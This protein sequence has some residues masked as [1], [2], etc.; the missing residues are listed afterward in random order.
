MDGVVYMVNGLQVPLTAK[1]TNSLGYKTKTISVDKNNVN[2]LFVILGNRRDIRRGHVKKIQK[3]LMMGDHF[4]APIVCNLRDNKY[5]LIDGNHRL[6]AIQEFLL[7]FSDRKV[8]VKIHYFENL[9][10]E[11]EKIE[12]TR[13]NCGAKQSTNDVVKQYWDDMSV[14]QWLVSKHGFPWA[15]S[16]IWSPNAIE[17]K[18]LWSA[19]VG[20]P[21]FQGNGFDF[22]DIAMDLR[23]PDAKIIREFLKEYMSIF[24]NPDR[25]QPQYK[26]CVFWAACR[27]W[28]DNYQRMDPS[29]MTKRLKKLL[30]SPRLIYWAQ[31]GGSRANVDVAMKEFKDVMN[32]NIKDPV[33]LFI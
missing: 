15:V 20:N 24:G 1:G 4:R 30:G 12:Y 18:T 6:A 3:T 19:Y 31:Q 11:E 26:Q 7:H 22:I 33:K 28:L 5:R 23:K 14:T 9:T 21:T 13:W 2:K 29:R 25:S 16:H 17:F 32:G 27:I 10:D 8:E